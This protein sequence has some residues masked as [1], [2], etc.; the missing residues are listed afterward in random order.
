MAVFETSGRVVSVPAQAAAIA[1]KGLLLVA[2]ALLLVG[3]EEEQVEVMENIRAIKTITV[4]DLGSGQLRR[5]PGVVEAVD[6]SSVSFE[7][8]GN[9]REVNVNVGDRVDEGQ[10]LATLDETPFQLNVE[11]AE[12]ELGRANAQLAE[13][14][15]QYQRQSTLYD[16]GWVAKSAYDEALAARDS[17]AN[18]V[19]F[20]TS[21][22]DLARR[23]LEKTVLAA[24]FEGVIANKFVDPFQ[25]I[26]RG[27]KVFEI[28][29]EAAMQ[30]VLSVPEN[31]IS[32]IHLGLPAEI[33]FPSEQVESLKGEVSE[34]GTVAGDANAFPVKVTLA[35]PSDKVLPGMTAEVALILGESS[36]SA[37]YLVPLSAIAA[38]NEPKQA[39]VFVFNPETS[40]VKMT[41]IGGKGVEGNR[42]MITEG[43]APGDVI[44]VAGVSFLRDGQEVKLMS[45][46][47]AQQENAPDV[48]SWQ[49]TDDNEEP[50]VK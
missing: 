23:D 24:P 3:C 48:P 2:S 1:T 15:T 47:A 44:A 25:E 26:A 12:A 45:E 8:G 5:F 22:L 41:A 37:S 50:E 4:A 14:E 40:T 28:Y 36:G 30:V 20:A 39:F 34:I 31:A 11:G 17:V 16:K 35:E 27:E 7:V 32:E 38:G 6:T 18:Q 33:T 42:V 21:K 19:S 49:V 13:K 10:A 43:I 9:T 46:Q 29:R